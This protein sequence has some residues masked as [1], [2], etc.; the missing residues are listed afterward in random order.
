[1]P[2]R[3]S[4]SR[5]ARALAF[6][7]VAAFGAL[8][9]G[10]RPGV[11]AQLRKEVRVGVGRLP[12]A[13][14]PASALEGTVP[15]VARQMFDTLVAYRD[16]S[17]DVVPGLATRWNTSRDGLTWTFTIRDGVRFHD[18]VPMT[19]REVAAS[20]ERQLVAEGAESRQAWTALLRGVPGVVKE[21]RAADS[22]TVV[23]GLVQA[24]APL[25]TVLAHPGLSVVRT[26][27]GPDGMPRFVGTG[28]YR[29]VDVSPGRLA[30]EAVIGHW[31]GPA[32]A[33]RI[34]FLEVPNDEHAEAELDAG[35][36]D[37]WFPDAPP[38]RSDWALSIPGLRV[39]YLAFQTEKEPFSHKQ[40][41]QAVAAALD[42]VVIGTAL[43][44]TAVPLQSFLPPG[45][46][47]RREGSPVLGGTR[48]MVKRLLS[49]GAWPK[50]FTATMAFP[51]EPGLARLA[52]TLRA[53]LAAAEIPV[54][55]R[56][57]RVDTLRAM[58]QPG[59][60]DIALVEGRVTAGDPHLLLYPL[61][62]SEGASKGPRAAN[63]SFYRN[64]RL[65]DVLIRASQVS[66]RPERARLYQRAQA[67]MADEMPWAPLYVRLVWAVAR[68]EV[69]GLR[70]HPTG[71]HRLTS[72][73]L[74]PTGAPQ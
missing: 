11:H 29:A 35:S 51:E 66:F 40:V 42:P 55:P 6:L 21:V 17:T 8:L 14:D 1:M 52:E 46:W 72:I 16:G 63:Y 50:G 26:V 33:E 61:S 65:D 57:E 68:P 5:R 31:S 32:R 48:D 13:I 54:Q 10:P 58:L 49:E 56:P 27:T 34:V 12:A 36:L 15:L 18:G 44:R 22:R 38:R 7:L 62:T 60:H 3:L 19:A 37:I 24:Y 9:L 53:T 4:A 41:R 47:A 69:R 59:D 39:G 71:F 30:L 73:A 67:L 45:V 2:M 64:P 20:F 28:S 74:D 23:F 25:L 43:G 70:L